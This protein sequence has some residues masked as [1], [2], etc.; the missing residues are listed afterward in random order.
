MPD[1]IARKNRLIDKTREE[2]SAFMVEIG[3]KFANDL[4][5]V[6]GTGVFD[7][8]SIK[9]EM[10]ALGYDEKII[11]SL[12]KFDEVFK[13]SEAYFKLGE[14]PFL[15]TTE[16]EAA[17][18]VMLQSKSDMVLNGIK[19]RFARDMV[20][21]AVS[22]KLSGKDSKLII[23][24]VSEKFA[25]EGRRIG[26][27]VDTALSSFDRATKKM[28]FENAGIERFIYVGPSDKVTR[29]S[30]A[31]ALASENQQTGWTAADIAAFPGVDMVTGGGYNCRHDWL[32]FTGD[33]E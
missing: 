24:E 28:L 20:D 2:L 7:V 17:F 14:L 29:D 23:S 26:T 27:E 33:A 3:Q 12:S 31:A 25:T 5:R 19:D 22:S 1:P 16:N 11:D 32:P 15:W 13:L 10:T 8:A 6:V 4:S 9:A 30:C 18:S 21:Y